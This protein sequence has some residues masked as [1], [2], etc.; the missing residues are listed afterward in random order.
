MI[1]P[2]VAAVINR[3]E[4]TRPLSSTKRIH[5][6]I[7]DTLD[8]TDPAGATPSV[9]RIGTTRTV[10]FR[11]ACGTATFALPL[12]SETRA[13][14]SVMPS[15]VQIRERRKASQDIPDTRS[16]IRPPIAYMLFWYSHRERNDDAALTY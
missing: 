2:K 11:S 7:S 1:S 13:S 15:G 6:D 5:L 16:M 14:V 8:H 12:I 10:S 3:C 9:L 4:P